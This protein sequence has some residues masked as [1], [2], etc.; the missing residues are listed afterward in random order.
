[1]NSPERKNTFLRSK[2][3]AVHAFQVVEGVAGVVDEGLVVIKVAVLPVDLSTHLS[4]GSPYVAT[5]FPRLKIV[6]K[7]LLFKLYALVDH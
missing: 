4:S 3:F 6:Q 7:I 5:L 1:M 2:E